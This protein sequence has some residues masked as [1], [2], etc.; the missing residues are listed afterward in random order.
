MGLAKV[1]LGLPLKPWAPHENEGVRC[2]KT[3]EAAD[4][5]CKN[6][7]KDK[8]PRIFAVQ[9]DMFR[10]DA[11]MKEKGLVPKK[12]LLENEIDPQRVIWTGAGN[13]AT[14]HQPAG[15]PAFW[16]WMNYGR[17]KNPV[18]SMVKHRAFNAAKRDK[19]LPSE[20]NFTVFCVFMAEPGGGTPGIGLP[21]SKYDPGRK[22]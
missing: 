21:P 8:R 14:L 5:F 6:A 3:F 4:A 12:N 7:P 19:G 2:F 15:R 1:R 18:G 20:N 9:F 11:M 16:E 17:M 10:T 22:R 13:V